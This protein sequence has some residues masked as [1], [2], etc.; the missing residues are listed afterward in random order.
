MPRIWKSFCVLKVAVSNIRAE[1]TG[2]YKNVINLPA[3]SAS[4][5]FLAQYLSIRGP[6][7]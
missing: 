1:F 7:P 6:K 5:F 4:G 3:S 2:S